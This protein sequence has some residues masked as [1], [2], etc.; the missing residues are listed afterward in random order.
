MNNFGS[1]VPSRACQELRFILNTI[2]A[3]VK[4]CLCSELTQ[5]TSTD[6]Q[7][8]SLQV[9]RQDNELWHYRFVL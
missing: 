2:K 7:I 1:V 9:I 6:D 4:I 8:T 3:P 5:E